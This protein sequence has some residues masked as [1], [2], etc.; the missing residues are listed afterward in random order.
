MTAYVADTH[1]VIWYL[2]DAP[3]LSIPAH[4]AFEVARATGD[5]IFVSSITLVEITYLAEKGKLPANVPGTVLNALDDEQGA[6]VLAPV[7]RSVVDT[8]SLIPRSVVPDMP[9]RIIAATALAY[10]VPLLITRDHQIRQS[11][12]QTVW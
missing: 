5:P 11:N 1:A 12:L 7:D 3:E 8:L 2:L 6:L 10:G 4:A 9:D